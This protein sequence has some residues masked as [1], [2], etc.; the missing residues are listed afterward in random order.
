VS[1]KTKDMKTFLRAFL[2]ITCVLV[3]D[4]FVSA[5]NLYPS[6]KF[7]Y[8]DNPPPPGIN[9]SYTIAYSI[10]NS[11]GTNGSPFGPW[12]VGYG[13]PT[14]GYYPGIL[15]SF[16]DPNQRSIYPPSSPP[17]PVNCYRIV[18]AVQ[19]YDGTNYVTKYG[20]SA[21]ADATGIASGSLE[22]NVD[23]F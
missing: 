23:P 17:Y 10:Q 9:Y 3:L 20:Y 7:E 19:R 15:W 1:Q 12:L 2:L 14:T 8:K 21:W 18:V 6:F 22:I 13:T 4:S 5:V 16:T 11:D